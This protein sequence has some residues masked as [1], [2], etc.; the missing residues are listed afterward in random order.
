MMLAVLWRTGVAGASRVGWEFVGTGSR[1]GRGMVRPG[2]WDVYE[3]C[4][5]ESGLSTA[6]AQERAPAGD[7]DLEIQL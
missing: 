3:R 6:G 4:P 1:S 2:L 5:R 7:K